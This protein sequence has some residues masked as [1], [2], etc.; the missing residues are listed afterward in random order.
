MLWKILVEEVDNSKAITPFTDI[1]NKYHEYESAEL[2]KVLEKLDPSMSRR[3]HPNN[4]RK[5]LR[6]EGRLVLV[7]WLTTIWFFFRS[8]EILVQKQRKHSEILKEQQ[9]SAGGSLLGGGLRYPNSVV[10]WLQCD[11][12]ILDERLNQR[13]DKMVEE[14][15]VNELLEFHKQ[16]NKNRLIDKYVYSPI[17]CFQMI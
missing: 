12:N 17:C 8:I 2:H 10:F 9:S 11:Q 15:L 1:Y 5:I 6:Y 13:V 14:G 4:K 7:S 3:L 16:Y